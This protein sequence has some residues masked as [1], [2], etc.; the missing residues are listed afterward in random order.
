MRL[1]KNSSKKTKNTKQTAIT[2]QRKKNYRTLRVYLAYFKAIS[3]SLFLIIITSVFAFSDYPTKFFEA[4]LQGIYAKS[5]NIGFKI[6]EVVV[7]GRNKTD[8]DILLKAID[9]KRGDPILAINLEALRLKI[10]RLEWVRE[11]TVIRQLPNILYIKITERNPIAIWQN[12]QKIYLVDEDGTP[13][14]INQNQQNYKLPVVV[15]EGAPPKTPGI[16]EI[17]KTYPNIFEKLHALC[18]IRER[19]WNLFLNNNIVV[20]LS[21]TNLKESLSIL[22]QLLNENRIAEDVKEIDFRPS[23]RFFVKVNPEVVEKIKNSR[24]GKKT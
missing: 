20:K 12:N 14:Y 17:I 23:E 22:E 8:Q 16:L 15:G 18:R 4:V 10:E 9:I 6:E 2:S 21:D 1:K 19:R 7:Q 3:L 24:K 5:T 11:A 13:I